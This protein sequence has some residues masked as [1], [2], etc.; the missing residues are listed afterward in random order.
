MSAD[1]VA[2]ISPLIR[3]VMSDTEGTGNGLCATFEVE[4]NV[5]AWAQVTKSE[6]NVTY[7]LSKPP[8]EELLEVNRAL[9]SAELLSWQPDKFA[10]WSFVSSEPRVVAKVVDQALA[11]LFGLGDY[12]VNGQLVRL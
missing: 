10:T 6:F 12:S 7:P 2:E 3:E 1:Q 11:H 8:A 9:P 4:G 5:A